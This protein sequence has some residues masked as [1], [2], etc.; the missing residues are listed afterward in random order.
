MTSQISMIEGYEYEPPTP[1]ELASKAR[2]LVKPQDQYGLADNGKTCKT[3]KHLVYHE[4][5]KR[6]YKCKKWVLSMSSASDV[7]VSWPAC[8]LY[9]PDA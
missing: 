6:W 5:S 1:T 4:R 8:K 7:R 2:R 9:E 3:C